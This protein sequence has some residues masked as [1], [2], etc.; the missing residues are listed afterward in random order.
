M[1]AVETNDVI[2]TGLLMPRSPRLHW[3][4]LWLF[5]ASTEELGPIDQ[6]PGQFELVT[7]LAGYTCGVSFHDGFACVHPSLSC[8]VRTFTDLPLDQRLTDNDVVARCAVMAV[9]LRPGDGSH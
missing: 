6:P 1:I 5:N 7:L 3:G 8:V 2:G 9:D 4:E